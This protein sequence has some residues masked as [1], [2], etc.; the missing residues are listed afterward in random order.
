MNTIDAQTRFGREMV[1]DLKSD[2]FS[3][4]PT[5]Y[6][7]PHHESRAVCHKCGA[8][9]EAAPLWLSSI[10]FLWVCPGEKACQLVIIHLKEG[11]ML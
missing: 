11:F 10:C 8:N 2:L 6:K 9:H 3:Q 4:L 5:L 1:V 7:F